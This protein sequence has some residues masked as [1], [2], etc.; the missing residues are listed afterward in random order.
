M[1]CSWSQRQATRRQLK[2]CLNESPTHSVNAPGPERPSRMHA[3]NVV[4]DAD[5]AVLWQFSRKLTAQVFSSAILA[6]ATSI[7]RYAGRSNVVTIH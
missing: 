5:Q 3:L 7:R 4:N 1:Y 6:K 2:F